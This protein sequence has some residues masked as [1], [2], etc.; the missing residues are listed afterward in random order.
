[1]KLVGYSK[2]MKG[3]VKKQQQEKQLKECLLNPCFIN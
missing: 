1:M 3:I 2:K